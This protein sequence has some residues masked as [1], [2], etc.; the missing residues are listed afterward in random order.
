MRISKK[1]I[2]FLQ[3]KGALDQEIFKRMHVTDDGGKT[4]D[5]APKEVTTLKKSMKDV[6]IRES[7][8]IPSAVGSFMYNNGFFSKDANSKIKLGN[9]FKGKNNADLRMIM[10]INA[11]PGDIDTALSRKPAV[12][13]AATA[14][15]PEED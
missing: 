7:V 2:A 11:N 15:Y 14:E 13:T 3:H 4:L 5:F 10:D 8:V 1:V 12:K 9:E 6:E